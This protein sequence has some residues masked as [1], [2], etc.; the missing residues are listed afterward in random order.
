M[1]NFDNLIEGNILILGEK[2]KEEEVYKKLKSKLS[3]GYSIYFNNISYR[4]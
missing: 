2:N 1:D 4:C 3:K